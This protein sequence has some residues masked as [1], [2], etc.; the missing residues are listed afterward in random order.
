M[1]GVAAL[2]AEA[3]SCRGLDDSGADSS[4]RQ[5]VDVRRA[6]GLGFVAPDGGP[7]A[8]FGTFPNPSVRILKV[9]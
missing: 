4:V 5:R 2:A 8:S 6:P 7:R 3:P 1:D 9:Y